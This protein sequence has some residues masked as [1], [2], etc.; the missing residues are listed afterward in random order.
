[1]KNYPVKKIAIVVDTDCH[2]GDGTQD[3]YWHDK[4]ILYISL[5]QDGRE[6]YTHNCG[7]IH[8]LGG[9]NALGTNHKRYTATQYIRRGFP[10]AMTL[11]FQY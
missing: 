9:P 4:D 10:M 6:R 3:I 2:H 7:A 1:M 5:H 11:I 8:E